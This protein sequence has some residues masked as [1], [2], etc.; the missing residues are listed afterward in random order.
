MTGNEGLVVSVEVRLAN[1]LIMSARSR[2]VLQRLMRQ[3]V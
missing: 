2:F 1:S 3:I